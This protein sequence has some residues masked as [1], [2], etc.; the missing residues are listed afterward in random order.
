MPDIEEIQIVTKPDSFMMDYRMRLIGEWTDTRFH[1]PYLYETAV[2]YDQPQ[3]LELGT[4]DGNSTSAFL[5]AAEETGGH[6]TSCD[7]ADPDL[8]DQVMERWLDSV[9]WT[10]HKQ[11]D[12][13]L[14]VS[15]YDIIFLDTSHLLYETYAEMVKFLPMLNPGG[16]MLFHDTQYIGRIGVIPKDNFFMATSNGGR[17]PVAWALDQ[18][19]MDHNLT[20]VNYPGS[21]GLGEICH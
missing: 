15:L 2:T 7:I 8:P 4:R 6:V 9:F 12:M 18:F 3:I 10:F 21:F 20:W 1:L 14:P 5:A 19:C 17:G 13:T 11:D 16:R